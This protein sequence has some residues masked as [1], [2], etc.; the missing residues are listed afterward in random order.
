MSLPGFLP[1]GCWFALAGADY[2]GLS[3]MNAFPSDPRLLETGLTGVVRSH[4]RRG[5]ATALKVHAIDFARR[6]GAER[7]VTRNEE[8]NP[9]YDLNL[10]LGFRPGPA[11]CEYEKHLSHP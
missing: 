6:R 10:M 11:M 4:R 1:E 8:N 9:M 7:I 2:V 5:I 3:W